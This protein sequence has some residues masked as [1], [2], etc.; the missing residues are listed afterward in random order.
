MKPLSRGLSS[1]ETQWIW[2]LD[3]A[4]L[5]AID[6]LAYR[7]GLFHAPPTSTGSNGTACCGGGGGGGNSGKTAPSTKQ[8]RADRLNRM[9]KNSSLVVSSSHPAS[10]LCNGRQVLHEEIRPYSS[11][12]I[13]QQM[14]REWQK[15]QR[16]LVLREAE[17]ALK[18]EVEFSTTMRHPESLFADE[19]AVMFR[20]GMGAFVSPAAPGFSGLFR[21]HW[22]DFMVTEMVTDA[23]G[24]GIALSRVLDWSVPPLP[25]SLLHAGSEKEQG[26][27]VEGGPHP[28]FFSVNVEERV[29]ELVQGDSKSGEMSHTEVS[30]G[31]VSGIG[32]RFYLQAYLHKQ[33]IAHSVALSNIAQTLRMHPTG[34]SVAGIKDYIGDTIQR[35]RLKNIT[36]AAALEANRVFRRKKW[37]M[38]LSDFS[39]ETE[40][41]YPGRLFGNQ[42]KIVLRDVTAPREDVERAINDF[43]V[44]GFPNYYGCQRFSWFGGKND[45]AFALLHHN[46]L[47]FAFRF[48]GYTSRERTLRELLQREKKY[49]N[50]VQ[51]EYRRNVV[52]RLRSIAMDPGEL[53]VAPFLS[54]PALG[55][56][57][58]SVDGGPISKKQELII[59]QLRG[60]F[61][62]LSMTSRRLTAQRLSSYLWNQVLTLRLHHFGS[63]VLV[64]DMLIPETFRQVE[65]S[66]EDRKDWYREGIRFIAD[67]AEKDMHS[68]TDVV[69]VGFSFNGIQRPRNATGEYYLQVCEKYR[70]D[71]Y[72]QHTRVGIRDFLEPPRPIIRKPLNLSYDYNKAE[73]KL[74]L[75][76]A[77]ERGCYANVAITELM[78]QLRCAGSDDILTLPAPDAMWDLGDRDP[79]YVTTLQDIYSGFQDGLG[80]VTDEHEVPLV[81]EGKVWDCHNGPLFLPESADP[82]RKAYR[83]GERHLL[84]NMA[85]RARDEEMMKRRL[86]EKPLAGTLKDGEVS[87]Y[88]GH[89]VPMSPNTRAKKI[90]FKVLRRQRRF[91][92]APK[93]AP[94]L[95]RGAQIQKRTAVQAPFK[96]IDRN[97]W[98]VTW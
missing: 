4:T 98:N 48:L 3:P 89:T 63:K 73:S 21:Q 82:V 59:L 22:K 71:W 29:A 7:L 72:A 70:L 62:D 38:R 45:A 77:L 66:P 13:M 1:G 50:P 6:F 42:F 17:Q 46:W 15:R 80:F 74:T 25:A 12:A 11:L 24:S 40:P 20:F 43:S 61:L 67:D 44:H 95:K 16:A 9:A 19:D 47:A 28:S 32:G 78:K 52:R 88:A 27:D 53:D 91:P 35:V 92:G 33:H 69:H 41:L 26:I 87:Q 31:E 57:P 23:S 56:P 96:T 39:Y 10:S 76:F 85:R 75:E 93:A 55:V 8:M 36:P 94:R 14:M 51:D 49:P 79:G 97:T 58:T 37:A 18:D 90:F 54:C 83:W 86:F 84:R 60:A 81:G 68:I 5:H 64:G 2:H 30:E 34:I 65:T